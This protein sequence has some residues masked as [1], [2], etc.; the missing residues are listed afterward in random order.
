ME[1]EDNRQDRINWIKNLIQLMCCDGS[2]TDRERKFLFKV[3]RQLR[4]DVPDWDALLKS[5]LHDARVRYPIS[6]H[7]TALAVLKSLIVIANADGR[8]NDDENR[9]IL[10]F[11]KVIGVSDEQIKAIVD[12]INA[13]HPARGTGIR[14]TGFQPVIPSD[15]V[16]S[17]SSPGGAVPRGA[18][19]Q[20]VIPSGTVSSPGSPGGAGPQPA[21]PRVAGFQ[22][23]VSHPAAGGLIT[24][25]KDDFEQIDQFVELVRRHG[26]EA[27]IVTL[28]DVVSRRQTLGEITCFHA[29]GQ[30]ADTVHRYQRLLEV[31]TGRTVAVLSRYQGHHVRYLLELN[32]PKCVIEP[33]YAR[34]IEQICALV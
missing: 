2:I 10:S 21:V 14:G 9:Y 3:A 11:A 7:D 24:V 30:P 25:V 32:I 33:V 31:V 13:K 23:A 6:D 18:G 22:P 16:S 17:P 4:V 28:D 19:F 26:R 12:D 34:D 1:T 8:I 15:T 27:R 29:A 5:V 20:P